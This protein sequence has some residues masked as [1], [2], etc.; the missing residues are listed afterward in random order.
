MI[1]LNYLINHNVSDIQDYSEHI[2][3]EHTK[4]IDN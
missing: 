2:N 3:K 4:V 1:N